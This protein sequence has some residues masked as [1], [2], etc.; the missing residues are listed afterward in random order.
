VTAGTAD[1]QSRQRPVEEA[2]VKGA[3]GTRKAAAA[4]VVVVAAVA[5]EEEEPL[6]ELGD[7]TW[8]RM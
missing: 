4:A 5:A 7:R 2:G 8:K 3:V 6:M 1:E